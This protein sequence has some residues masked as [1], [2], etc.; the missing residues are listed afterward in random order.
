MPANYQFLTGIELK[1]ILTMTL[2]FVLMYV[3]L[4]WPTLVKNHLIASSYVFLRSFD[5]VIFIT[6]LLAIS[7]GSYGGYTQPSFISWI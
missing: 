2:P 6:D 7:K 1:Y 3:V 5:G 4:G